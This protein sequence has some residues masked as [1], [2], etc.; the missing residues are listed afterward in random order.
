MYSKTT[1]YKNILQGRDQDD[2]LDSMCLNSPIFLF[3]QKE[4]KY[5]LIGQKSS[6]LFITIWWILFLFTFLCCSK[7]HFPSMTWE[8]SWFDWALTRVYERLAR[9]GGARSLYCRN[10]DVK[11]LPSTSPLRW[12]CHDRPVRKRAP[13]WLVLGIV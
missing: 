5:I 3:I 6:F 9:V 10:C 12:H 13:T 11:Y 7:K 4:S 2:S 1:K 8:I